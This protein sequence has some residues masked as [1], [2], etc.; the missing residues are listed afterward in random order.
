[1]GALLRVTFVLV[2]AVAAGADPPT[3]GAVV[4]P[5]G[6]WTGQ[7]TSVDPNIAWHLTMTLVC[8]ETEVRGALE[9]IDLDRAGQTFTTFAGTWD[10]ALRRLRL[11]EGVLFE[12]LTPGRVTSAG[13]YTIDLDPTDPS[14]AT[15]QLGSEGSLHGGLYLSRI[16][17]VG[18]SGSPAGRWQ[19]LP[20]LQDPAVSLAIR[21]GEGEAVVGTG[22][23]LDRE[24]RLIRG[25]SIQGSRDAEEPD[26]WR[27]QTEVDG[28]TESHLAELDSSG[29]LMRLTSEGGSVVILIRRGPAP[30]AAPGTQG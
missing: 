26:H 6:I 17:E 16:G 15:G 7:L 21:A 3:D 20:S 24:A 18:D 5:S 11:H 12:D 25:V 2:L 29:C 8:K 13:S 30:E 1:M 19:A 23:F 28:V 10:P 9:W 14:F 22:A 4:D 27:L